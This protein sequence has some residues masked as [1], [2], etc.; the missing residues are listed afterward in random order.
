MLVRVSPPGYQVSL[1]LFLRNSQLGTAE[2]VGRDAVRVSGVDSTRLSEAVALWQ[3][4]NE[5]AKVEFVAE[6]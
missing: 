5:L 1:W 2:R 4:L 6:E 3:G